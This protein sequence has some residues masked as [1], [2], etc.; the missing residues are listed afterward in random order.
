MTL[1]DSNQSQCSLCRVCRVSSLTYSTT[2]QCYRSEQYLP[3]VQ[4]APYHPQ[5]KLCPCQH[6]L[7]HTAACRTA[8]QITLK[9]SNH[10][11]QGKGKGL[12]TCVDSNSS[13]LQ[14]RRWQLMIPWC[15]M[16]PSIARDGKQLT[17]CS[18]QT[19]HHPN[20]RNMPSPRSP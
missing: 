10:A 15:I 13:A 20:Q 18:T 3:G 4:Q 19:Y 7:H 11:R 17:R 16:R 9:Y 1:I 8:E 5:T 14:S 6:P 2:R 12:G